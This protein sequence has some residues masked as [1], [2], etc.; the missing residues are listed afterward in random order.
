[1]TVYRIGII[2]SSAPDGG[3]SL[4][5]A[6]AVVDALGVAVRPAEFDVGADRYLRTGEVLPPDVLAGLRAQD[7]VFSG[8]PPTGDRPGIAP[9]VLDR[10]IIFGLRR[11]LDLAINLRV[12][13]GVGE[14]AGVDVAVVR[15]NSEGAYSVEGVALHQGTDLET[16]TEVSITTYPATLRCV[17]FA[18][19]LA[20]ARGGRVTLAHKTKVLTASGAVWTRATQVVAE[21]YPD[22]PSDAENIDTLCANMVVEP[23]RYD[24][25][26]TDNVFGDILS[27]VA[28]AATRSADHSGSAEL[29]VLPSGPSLFEPITGTGTPGGPL[30]AFSAAALMLHQLGEVAAADA[31]S[32][33]TLAVAAEREPLGDAE[34]VARVAAVAGER[35]AETN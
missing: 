27:D 6:L 31:L 1:V 3:A 20:R 16:A 25:I 28:S 17:R 15:E 29:T 2:R 13:R 4:D 22:V 19:E 10:G 33:G 7:A 12:F 35:L 26:V 9:G 11:A 32:R 30:K 23:G 18:F 34:L 14:L 24:V 5:L 8:G 21:E